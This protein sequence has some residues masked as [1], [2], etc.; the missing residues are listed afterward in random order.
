MNVI[1]Y[2]IRVCREDFDASDTTLNLASLDLGLVQTMDA[3]ANTFNI[4]DSAPQNDLF[5]EFACC[6]DATKCSVIDFTV[7]D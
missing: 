2:Y 7:L 6:V 1:E 5:S 3:D 4:G